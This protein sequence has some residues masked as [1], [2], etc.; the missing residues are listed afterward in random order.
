MV[1]KTLGLLEDNFGIHPDFSTLHY[2]NVAEVTRTL[3]QCDDTPQLV[4][5]NVSYGHF[6]VYEVPKYWE[7]TD[8]G[9]RATLDV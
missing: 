6:V 4:V 5:I 8:T 2:M 1:A 7:R 3:L 9:L